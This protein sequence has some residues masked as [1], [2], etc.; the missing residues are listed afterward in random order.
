MRNETKEKGR[1][2]I[3]YL[4]S[5]TSGTGKTIRSLLPGTSEIDGAVEE[6]RHR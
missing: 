5:A 2:S 6:Q 4:R 1:I 3:Q